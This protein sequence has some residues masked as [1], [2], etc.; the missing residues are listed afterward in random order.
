M[1]DFHS[2]VLPQVD[3]GSQSI[4]ESCLM[5]KSLLEQGVDTV[6]A[7]PH[8]YANS[9]SVAS[10]LER[11]SA[12]YEVLKEETADAPK[13]L[14]GAEVR[15]Y[16]GISRLEGLKDLRVENTDLLLLEMPM[17]KWSEYTVNELLAISR[18]KEYK[19]VLAH[20]ER[21]F[22]FQGDGVWQNLLENDLMFQVNASFFLSPIT[23]RKALRLLKK[24]FVHFLGSDCH[25][26]ETRPPRIG[27]A[28]KLLE[29]KLDA[30][31]FRRFVEYGYN[32]VK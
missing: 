9:D 26:M 13:L 10:F 2:H 6:L 5:L 30:D 29:K 31:L 20:I 24:G 23:R 27:P 17:A 14:P 8:F 7:T 3:D 16:E 28:Y 11:R 4:E 15:Y 19:P 18:A 12:A 25:D 22:D 21:C 32:F 1:I